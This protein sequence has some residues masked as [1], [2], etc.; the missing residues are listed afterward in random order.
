M[1]KWCYLEMFFRQ[2]EIE[3][4][5][6]VAVCISGKQSFFRN[7]QIVFHWPDDGLPW[8]ERILK[9][10]VLNWVHCSVNNVRIL[11][12]RAKTEFDFIHTL[13]NSI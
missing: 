5:Q 10:Q 8:V 4:K 7:S 11:L 13:W 2:K 9:R 6:E 12:V 3:E 1:F